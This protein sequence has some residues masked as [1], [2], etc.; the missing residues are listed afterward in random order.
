MRPEDVAS[1]W[2]EKAARAA[3]YADPFYRSVFGKILEPR[4]VLPWDE[5][6]LADIQEMRN[7]ARSALAA[8]L[9][10]IQAQAMD[11]LAALVRETW[12][13]YG[14]PCPWVGALDDHAARLRAEAT[15]PGRETSPNECR[16]PCEGCKHNCGACEVREEGA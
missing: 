8:V 9:P 4:E 16:C 15:C 10:E 7:N 3:Y 6:D 1:E 11:D 2:V 13:P 14:V 5:L 12:A